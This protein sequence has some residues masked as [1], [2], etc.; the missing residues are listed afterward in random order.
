[1]K[2]LLS[3]LLILATVATTYAAKPAKEKKSKGKPSTELSEEML[4]SAIPIGSITKEEFPD[5]NIWILTGTATDLSNVRDALITAE[6]ENRTIDLTLVNV[7]SIPD[8][9]FLECTTLAYISAPE[10]SSIGRD[11][12]ANCS[13]LTT[14]N[15]PML[16]I[17][18]ESAFNSCSALTEL[19][20]PNV[21]TIKA[22]AFL[23]CD[24]LNSL[25]LGAD[26]AGIGE[27]SAD[28]FDGFNTEG[29]SLSIKS[30]LVEIEEE[31]MTIQSSIE[32]TFLSINDLN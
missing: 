9:A 1:M 31:V 29:C 7:T 24:A 10:V 14:V 5:K 32:L 25:T 4:A 2:R 13:S 18:G 22:S 21:S 15:L 28:A 3:I 23:Q 6:T 12:F 17:V 16:G 26:G 20:L 11:A 8:E 30:G 19:D 27:L